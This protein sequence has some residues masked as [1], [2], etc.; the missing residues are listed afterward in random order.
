MFGPGSRHPFGKPTH[1]KLQ[2]LVYYTK[3][4]SIVDG[5]DIV[6]DPVCKWKHGPVIRSLYAALKANGSGPIEV[7]DY[8]NTSLDD[9]TARIADIVMYSYGR[10][11]AFELS[12][13]THAEDPWRLTALN[14]EIRVDLIREYYSAQPFARNFPIDADKPFYPI[15]TQSAYA[16]SF[17]MDDA[18]KRSTRVYPSFEMYKRVVDSVATSFDASA[19]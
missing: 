9:R 10:L 18:D 17:D 2:K 13:L 19:W 6:S 15:L 11:S 7:F 4:W 12:D 16:F 14:A 8:Q 3:V 5:N 1:M